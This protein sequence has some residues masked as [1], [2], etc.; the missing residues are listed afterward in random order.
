MA[1]RKPAFVSTP[2]H[3]GF[4]LIKRL[5]SEAGYSLVEVMVAIMLLGLAIIPMVSMFDAG[6]RAAVLGSNYD[7]ARALAGKQMERAQSLPYG[8]VKTSFPAPTASFDSS[9]YSQTTGL[10]E[11][12]FP[13]FTYDVERQ[14]VNAPAAGGST[15]S[16]SSTDRGLMRITITVRW[17]GSKEFSTVSLIAR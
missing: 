6:L 10:T 12:A 17:D 7:Q 9:G 1:P 3:R 13:N 2:L 14:F 4:R 16:N 15:F 5:K 8:T 11:P